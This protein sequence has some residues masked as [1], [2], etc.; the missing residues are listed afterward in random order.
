MEE[1]W[2]HTQAHDLSHVNKMIEFIASEKWYQG[3]TTILKSHTTT[4]IFRSLHPD[5][6]IETVTKWFRIGKE[7]GGDTHKSII[8]LLG[9][10]PY[11][12]VSIFVVLG[13]TH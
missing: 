1:L 6:Q 8:D 3:L 7:A 10:K 12:L 11:S 5:S 2:S 13:D 4:C 9:H